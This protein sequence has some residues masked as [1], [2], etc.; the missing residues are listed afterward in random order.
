MESG[1]ILAAVVAYLALM[2]VLGVWYGRKIKNNDDFMVAGRS[3]SQL[4]LTGTLLATWTGAGTIIGRANFSYTY[5][6]LASIF[7]SVG[8]PLGILIMYFFLAK[9]IRA[10]GKYTVPQIIELRYGRGV[11]LVAAGAIVIAYMAIV[12]EQI[13]A[14]GYILNLTTGIPP[15]VGE[16]VGLCLILFTAVAGGILSLAY[17]DAISAVLITGAMVGGVVFVLFSL[18]GFTGLAA[19]LP[20]SQMTWTGGLTSIQLLG[21]ILPGLFLFLGDQNMYQRF[22]AA[23]SPEVARK[24]ALGFLVGD[25]VFYGA[26]IILASSAAVLLPEI[27]PDTAILRLATDS[28][29]LVMGAALL[30]AGT[31]FVITTGN[32]FVL[33]ASSN[34]V[35]D[36]Y[37][38]LT[39]RRGDETRRMLM[40]TRV[41]IV[42]VGVVAYGIAKLFP[43]VLEIQVF[44]YTMYGAVITPCLLAVFLTTRVTPAG[45]VASMLTGITMTVLWEFGLDK[46]YDWNSVLVSLPLAIAALALVSLFTKPRPVRAE[47]SDAVTETES[48]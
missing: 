35:Q 41:T 8:P 3:L 16:V 37:V 2:V 27:A 48:A 12:S 7:Y 9:R 17:T 46:P 10:L 21:F 19:G 28:L 29:P 40:L 31:A 26:V 23:K 45:A 42:V 47:E 39:R 18:D 13:S 22:G 34:L 11:R 43:N 14:L 30:M 20:D 4:I 1:V 24:S 6:P 5:G 44:A 36:I 38:S 33:S 15:E 25:V 32:S